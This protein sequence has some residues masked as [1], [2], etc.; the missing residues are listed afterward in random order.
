M[1]IFLHTI[2]YGKKKKIETI[3][4]SDGK[5]Q[6]LFI[7]YLKGAGRIVDRSC[8]GVFSQILDPAK[9]KVAAP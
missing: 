1:Y 7:G 9:A 2:S 8:K 4:D 5:H 3:I 6:I